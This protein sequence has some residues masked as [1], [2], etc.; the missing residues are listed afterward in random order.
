MS[1]ATEVCVPETCALV[2]GCVPLRFWRD[3]ELQRQAEQALQVAPPRSKVQ[4]TAARRRR[5]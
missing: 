5:A 3:I 4:R 2:G 1:C